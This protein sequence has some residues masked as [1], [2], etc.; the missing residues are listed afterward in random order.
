MV[1]SFQSENPLKRK[2]LLSDKFTVGIKAEIKT[3]GQKPRQIRVLGYNNIEEGAFEPVEIWDTSYSE[4]ELKAARTLVETASK[5]LG[6]VKEVVQSTVRSIDIDAIKNKLEPVTKYDD[7]QVTSVAS[8]L[9]DDL[10]ALKTLAN[11]T[12]VEEIGERLEASIEV[13]KDKSESLAINLCRKYYFKRCVGF[14][15]EFITASDR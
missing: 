3:K 4:E 6:E 15:Y 12:P 1:G 9:L 10:G 7:S 11:N 2:I 13:I 5:T 8:G 14:T